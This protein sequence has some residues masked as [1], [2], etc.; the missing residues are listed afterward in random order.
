MEFINSAALWGMGLVAVPFII[1]LITRRRAVPKRFAAMRFV[2]LSHRNL[3]RKLRLKRILILLA[4]VLAVAALALLIAH[5]TLPADE[6][7]VKMGK[8]PRSLAIIVDNSI[9]MTAGKVGERPWD[10]AVTMAQSIAESMTAGQQAALLVT[11]PGPGEPSPS[12]SA[13]PKTLRRQAKKMELSH[14]YMPITESVSQ[15]ISLMESA[16]HRLRQI[17]LITDLQRAPWG[18]TTLAAPSGAELVVI[19]AGSKGRVDN[20]AVTDVIL[21]P[22]T[23]EARYDAT[24]KA[25][26]YARDSR[27]GVEVTVTVGDEVQTRGFLDLPAEGMASKRMSFSAEGE[28]ILRARAQITPD[29]LEVDDRYYFTARA[30]GRI[31]ALMVDGDPRAER[32]GAESYYLMNALN[33]KLE[34]RSRIDPTLITP[35]GLE[36]AELGDY[37]LVITANVGSYS[38]K[39]QDKLKR[40]VTGGG[41]LFISLGNNTGPGKFSSEYGELAPAG[42]YVLKE[43]VEPAHI[44]ADELSHPAV[45]IFSTP[46]GADLS[47]AEFKKYY[48]L[49]LSEARGEKPDVVLRFQDGS[50]ALVEKPLG[51]GRVAMWASTFDREWN[52]FCIYPAYLPLLQQMAL[53]LTGGMADPGGTDYT[54]GETA[55]FTC[56]AESASAWIIPPGSRPRRVELAPSGDQKRGE[57]ALKRGPGFYE[58]YCSTESRPSS[59]ADKPPEGV[60]AANSDVRESNLAEWDPGALEKHLERMGFKKPRVITDLSALSG[61]SGFEPGRRDAA[62]TMLVALAALLIMEG[63]LTRKG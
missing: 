5:P 55:R 28:G 8:A 37:D 23:G 6:R 35:P 42:L 21:E 14:V 38:E 63:F 19:D 1:H 53:Y 58:V 59:F 25:A 60:L 24:V 49:D 7:N 13:D 46:Q 11:N 22:S 56:P 9:S 30:G 33:P 4:R 18:E 36:E 12:F 17:L 57:A 16:H 40:Y 61:E 43:P 10:N 48:M 39:S 3:K 50:P 2:L 20:A 31:K 26:G 15:A 29:A 52:D 45:S 54:V 41:A 62:W 32:Y 44:Q 47:L 51:R 34:A 27:P